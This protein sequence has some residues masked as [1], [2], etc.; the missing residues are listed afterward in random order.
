[1]KPITSK[2]LRYV[3]TPKPVIVPKTPAKYDVEGFISAEETQ[4]ERMGRLVEA[5]ACGKILSS[6]NENYLKQHRYIT[7]GVYRWKI[8]LI[9][10]SQHRRSEAKLDKLFGETR[11]VI[12]GGRCDP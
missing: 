7:N 1:M 5:V 12:Q 3:K 4:L 11:S 10:V 6:E 2:F 8:G 9:N